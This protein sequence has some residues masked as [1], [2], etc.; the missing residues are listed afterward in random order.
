MPRALALP[1]TVATSTVGLDAGRT[2]MVVTMADLGAAA[3]I[4][5]PIE[6][7]GLL[8]PLAAQ[9]FAAARAVARMFTLVVRVALAAGPVQVAGAVLP[10]AATMSNLV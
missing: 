9:R 2:R 4:M 10:V 5:S 3:L 1:I 8:E 6:T 7:T